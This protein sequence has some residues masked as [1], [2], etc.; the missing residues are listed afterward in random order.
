M[1]FLLHYRN[2]QLKVLLLITRVSLQ[3]FVQGVQTEI[4]HNF[5][6]NVEQGNLIALFG[7]LCKCDNHFIVRFT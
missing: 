6:T 5:N 7:R 2:L 1:I 4:N 3:H